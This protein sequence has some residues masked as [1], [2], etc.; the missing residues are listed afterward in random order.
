MKNT[1]LVYIGEYDPPAILP[2]LV[3]CSENTIDSRNAAAKGKQT[4]FG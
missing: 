1:Y 2:R 3:H 4:L